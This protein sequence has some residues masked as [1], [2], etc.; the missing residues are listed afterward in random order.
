M[1][2]IVLRRFRLNAAD[3][4][5]NGSRKYRYIDIP[6]HYRMLDSD[7]E[8]RCS[9]AMLP[10]IA[11][12]D[13]ASPSEGERYYLRVLLHHVTGA[14]CY[15]DVRTFDG[16]EHATNKNACRG[17]LLLLVCNCLPV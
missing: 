1:Q 14:T 2:S 4:D 13:D 3:T 15:A 16:N 10:S 17:G 8:L 11:R 6:A 7:W 5:P 9:T 12:M